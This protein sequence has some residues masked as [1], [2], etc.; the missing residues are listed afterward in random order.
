MVNFFNVMRLSTLGLFACA[1]AS[2]AA[3]MDAPDGKIKYYKFPYDN[4]SLYRTSRK[5]N[6]IYVYTTNEMSMQ[7]EQFHLNPEVNPL[8]I[9]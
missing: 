5:R 7:I 9:A 3:D 8:L 4:R 2:Y 6:R 1:F